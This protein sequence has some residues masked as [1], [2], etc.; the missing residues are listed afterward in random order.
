MWP[1]GRANSCLACYD[2]ISYS[3]LKCMVCELVYDGKRFCCGINGRKESYF[4][5]TVTKIPNNSNLM[6]IVLWFTLLSTVHHSR[7]DLSWSQAPASGSVT[8]VCL[9]SWLF[10]PHAAQVPVHRVTHRENLPLSTSP[11]PV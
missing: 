4:S 11:N 1:H 3:D 5:Y 6:K 10:P 7:E 2:S 9:F 8:R